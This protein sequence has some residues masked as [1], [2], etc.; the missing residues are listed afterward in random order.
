MLDGVLNPYSGRKRTGGC[1]LTSF[2]SALNACAGFPKW[3]TS[4]QSTAYNLIC[5]VS[6]DLL[7]SILR[8]GRGRG[9][10]G[11]CLT[12][13]TTN[14]HTRDSRKRGS[15]NINCSRNNSKKTQRQA[16]TKQAILRKQLASNRGGCSFKGDK[17]QLS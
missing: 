1:C 10:F 2:A 13:A 9:T 5:R 6:S 14:N 7:P 8:P 12:C 16:A 3:A 15:S 11:L 4:G 17:G